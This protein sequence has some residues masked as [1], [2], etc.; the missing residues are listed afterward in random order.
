M[1][2]YS[3]FGGIGHAA[4]LVAILSGRIII[5]IILLFVVRMIVRLASSLCHYQTP[6]G[7]I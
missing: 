3:V 7:A 6:G 4:G 1:L 5:P 2:A